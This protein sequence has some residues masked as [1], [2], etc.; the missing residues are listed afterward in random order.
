MKRKKLKTFFLSL[1]PGFIGVLLALTFA[2]SAVG[3]AI[4]N[5]SVDVGLIAFIFVCAA[6]A[7]TAPIVFNAVK[8]SEDAAKIAEAI[9][10]V[11]EGE[12]SIEMP[13]VGVEYESVKETVERLSDI[14]EAADKAQLDFVN[15][16][17]H[18]LKTPIV[19]IRGFAKLLTS[20]DLTD[21]ERKEYST[22]IAEQSE[23]LINLTAQTL[24]LDKLGAGDKHFEK[25]WFSISETVEKC[26]VAMQTQWES[27]NLDMAIDID[28]ASVES[29]SDLVEQMI[30]NLLENAIKYTPEGKKVSVSVE[31]DGEKVVVT[32]SDEGVGMDEE[33][34]A[35][36][37]ERYYRGDPSRSTPGNGL[38]LA[39]VKKIAE[40]L[41]VKI[42]LESTLGQ[43]TEFR[44]I[45]G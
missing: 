43:G 39:T 34:K 25:S 7:G 20:D 11:R 33:T 15:D 36:A 41:D 45:F 29:N 40:V 17:S 31:K 44:L 18:E 8:R 2:A 16:F 42:Q 4:V 27:K 14:F 12:Y 28:D 38:G 22:I 6:I 21:D 5:A 10:K 24:M 30:T 9:E 37:F 23:R 19:S 13:E 26:V 32:V 1:I 35:R 3:V